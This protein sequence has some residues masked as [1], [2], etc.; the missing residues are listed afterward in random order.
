MVDEKI[1]AKCTHVVFVTGL[2]T[3]TIFPLDSSKNEIR[4]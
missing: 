3:L 1:E 4:I 2:I